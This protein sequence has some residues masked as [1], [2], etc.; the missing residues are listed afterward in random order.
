MFIV[1]TCDYYY[2]YYHYDYYY[3]LHQMHILHAQTYI[4][5]TSVQLFLSIFQDKNKKNSQTKKKLF[6]GW[7]QHWGTQG[8]QCLTLPECTTSRRWTLGSPRKV[9]NGK[10][11]MEFKNH[12]DKWGFSSAESYVDTKLYFTLVLWLLAHGCS[13]MNLKKWMKT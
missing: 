9:S 1:I 2:H 5:Y 7:A 10:K 13:T 6:E 12:Y 11:T 8:A 3:Y 4:I